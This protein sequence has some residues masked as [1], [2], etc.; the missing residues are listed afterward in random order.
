MSECMSFIFCMFIRRLICLLG[1]NE[2]IASKARA[3][4]TNRKNLIIKC[5]C[6]FCFHHQLVLHDQ[7]VTCELLCRRAVHF[8]LP[9]H[10]VDLAEQSVVER[11]QYFERK[12]K[13]KLVCPVAR[14]VLACGVSHFP[15]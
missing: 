4:T 5:F 10:A 6:F 3:A 7:C 2:P 9:M 8:L 14:L 11:R 13:Q 15:V 1:I 12:Q